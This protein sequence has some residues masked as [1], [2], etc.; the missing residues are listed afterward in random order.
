MTTNSAGIATRVSTVAA[1]MDFEDTHLVRTG[2][3]RDTQ[4]LFC[5]AIRDQVN[6]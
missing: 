2:A 6:P 1:M 3:D 5:A 4:F